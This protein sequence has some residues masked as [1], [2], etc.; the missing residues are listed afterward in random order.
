VHD[1]DTGFKKL[2]NTQIEKLK[3]LKQEYEVL[4]NL[5]IEEKPS[6]PGL[7]H[8]VHSSSSSIQQSHSDEMISSSSR[9]KKSSVRKENI[10][11]DAQILA[12]EKKQLEMVINNSMKKIEELLHNE[13]EYK[14]QLHEL[15]LQFSSRQNV[16]M[17]YETMIKTLKKN[18]MNQQEN[19]EALKKEN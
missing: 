8:K 6:P 7:L 18:E 14:K 16:D 2:K 4:R 15:K 17:E 12:L 10:S 9:Q 1:I 11:R 13:M 5:N 3:E 19:V